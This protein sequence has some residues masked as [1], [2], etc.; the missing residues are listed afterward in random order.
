VSTSYSY[1]VP[2]PKLLKL[3]LTKPFIAEI[4]KKRLKMRILL[5]RISRSTL[6]ESVF[7][8]LSLQSN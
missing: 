3:P 4:L 5:Q 1:P 2:L 8:V 6:K 7:E